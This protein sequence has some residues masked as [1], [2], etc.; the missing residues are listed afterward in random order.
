[1]TIFLEKEGMKG[2]MEILNKNMLR[3]CML[4]DHGFVQ[5]EQIRRFKIRL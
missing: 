1:M 2:M 4:P 5:L 3:K